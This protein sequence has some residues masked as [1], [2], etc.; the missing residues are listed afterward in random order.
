[1]RDLLEPFDLKYSATDM[2]SPY[3]LTGC[4]TLLGTG[5]VIITNY[6]AD[7]SEDR[8]NDKVV[9]LLRKIS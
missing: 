4:M 5:N 9:S 7:K 3:S 8:E 1:M 2:D 6:L